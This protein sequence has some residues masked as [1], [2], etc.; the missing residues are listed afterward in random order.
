MDD[1]EG[2]PSSRNGPRT[3]GLSRNGGIEA[4]ST[5]VKQPVETGR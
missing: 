3:V 2:T 1:A 4:M 5:S